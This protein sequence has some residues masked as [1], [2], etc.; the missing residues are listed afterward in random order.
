MQIDL[1]KQIIFV[2]LESFVFKYHLYFLG[3]LY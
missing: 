3:N 1:I 2:L